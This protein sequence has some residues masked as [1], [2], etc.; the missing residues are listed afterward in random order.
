MIAWKTANAAPSEVIEKALSRAHLCH[1]RC[2]V[3]PALM[4]R[5]RALRSWQAQRL[6]FTYQDLHRDP[7]Y[8][9][10]L[11]FFLT[12]LYGSEEYTARDQEFARAWPLLRR[13]MPASVLEMLASVL[14]LHALTLELDTTM[15]GIL[16]TAELTSVSYLTAYRAIG[17]APRRAEQLDLIIGIGEALA[18]LVQ[19]PWVSLAL[20]AAHSPAHAAGFGGLQ[21]FLER[22]YEAFGSLSHP[23]VLLQAIRERETRLMA[24][25]FATADHPALELLGQ[26]MGPQHG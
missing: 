14:Q 25:L 16:P 5:L 17:T 21:S 9:P 24:A 18:R 1:E 2:L 23:R 19:R 3:D 10:A 26:P 11:E 15:A 8:R 7:G 13:L 6:A 20:L 12:D 22:G 4:S